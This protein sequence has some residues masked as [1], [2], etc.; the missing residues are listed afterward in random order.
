MRVP[1]LRVWIRGHLQNP[2]SSRSEDRLSTKGK[3][4]RKN[5]PQH[6][7]EV[8]IVDPVIYLDL[9]QTQLSHLPQLCFIFWGKHAILVARSLSE[10][11]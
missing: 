8:F 3:H 1:P 4:N 9:P 7:G 6:K 11:A 10:N 2:H 5:I